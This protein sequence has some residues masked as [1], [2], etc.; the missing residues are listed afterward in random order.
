M[1]KGIIIFLASLVFYS[2]NFFKSNRDKAIA[3]VQQTKTDGYSG[4]DVAN[5]EAKKDPNN[6]FTWEAKK[7]KEDGVFLVT[8][9]DTAGWGQ[10]WEVTLKE[11]IVKLVTG[12]DYLCMKYNLSQLDPSGFFKISNITLDTLMVKN[13]KIDQGFW[14]NLLSSPKYK[15]VIVYCFQADVTNNTDKYITSAA[16]N[17]KLKLIFKEKTII[18]ASGETSFN[19]TI[20]KENTWNPGETKTVSI[21]TEDINKV[22]LNYTPAYTVFEINIEAQDPIGF[23]YNKVIFEDNLDEKWTTFI[24]ELNDSKGH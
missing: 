10:W 8:F 12:N 20:S 2:C 3:L 18:G 11:K 21:Q 9:G 16:I 13:E 22:Y 4:L 6:K 5:K 15:N 7:T 17:G 23:L 24:S 14:Q 1:K 19:T